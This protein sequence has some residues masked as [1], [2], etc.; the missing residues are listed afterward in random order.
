MASHSACYMLLPKVHIP[1]PLRIADSRIMASYSGSYSLY[2]WKGGLGA[3]AWGGGVVASHL[4]ASTC[5]GAEDFG[6]GSKAWGS[7]AFGHGGD[8]TYD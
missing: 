5:L 3:R 2:L 6:F 4:R 8:G 1:V 7:A